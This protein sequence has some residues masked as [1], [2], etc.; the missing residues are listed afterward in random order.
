MDRLSKE[1]ESQIVTNGCKTRYL[2]SQ[3]EKYATMSD[4]GIW[5][6]IMVSE[7]V[8]DRFNRYFD[9]PICN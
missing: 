2:Q 6:G 1:A 5:C 8:G 7:E 9:A 3:M 4:H